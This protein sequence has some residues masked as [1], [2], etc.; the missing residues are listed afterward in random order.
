MNSNKILDYILINLFKQVD[1]SNS[2]IELDQ[3]QPN[4][5]NYKDV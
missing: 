3:I 4:K 1:S 5:I 2:S